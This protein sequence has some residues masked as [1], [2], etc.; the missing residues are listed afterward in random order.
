MGPGNIKH[1][2]GQNL[3]SGPW[4]S[5]NID[6]GFATTTKK[7]KKKVILYFSPICPLLN[8]EC[9]VTPM[10]SDK[11]K[12]FSSPHM[13]GLSETVQ[14]RNVS[15]VLHSCSWAELS[16]LCVIRDRRVQYRSVF[17][18]QTAARQRPWKKESTLYQLTFHF[19]SSLDPN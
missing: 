18:S 9:I 12:T 7:K 15:L 1:S 4:V 5:S 3:A 16:A 6:C 2:K 10:T 17:M 13:F 14:V 11:S 8:S 19:L